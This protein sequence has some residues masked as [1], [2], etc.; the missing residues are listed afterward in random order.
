MIT[1]SRHVNSPV[2]SHKTLAL[3]AEH[4]IGELRNQFTPISKAKSGNGVNEDPVPKRLALDQ[5]RIRSVEHQLN[6]ALEARQYV[7]FEVSSFIEI[8]SVGYLFVCL[9]VPMSVVFGEE[10]IC[11][12]S[13]TL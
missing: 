11:F 10:G 13:S 1:V 3:A 7:V 6:Q 9:E 5:I 2:H 8:S 4:I 12:T